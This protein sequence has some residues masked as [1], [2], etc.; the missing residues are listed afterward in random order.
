MNAGTYDGMADET[1][2]RLTEEFR[3]PNRRLTEL[4]GTDFGWAA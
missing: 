4:I 3:G 1:R 2:A